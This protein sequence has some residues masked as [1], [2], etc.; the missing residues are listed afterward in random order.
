MS[1]SGK[2][3][4]GLLG[5][6]FGGPLGAIAGVYIGH[7][8][9]ASKPNSGVLNERAVFQI[10]LISILAYVAKV[11]GNVDRREVD[12]IFAFF[13]QIGFG[14]LQMQAIERTLNF[15]LTQDIHLESTCRNFRKASN[16]ESCLMLLRVVYLVVMADQK[17]HKNEKIAIEQIANYLGISDYDFEMLRAEFLKSDDK[18]YK[19]LGLEPGASIAEVKKA[20]RKLAL[21]YHPDRV[22]H[23]GK[24]Y[25]DV[26]EEKFKKINEAHEKVTK[27]LQNV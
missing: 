6:M 24:E 25:S 8:I 26:A 13:R 17:V 14:S 27:E 3:W 19:I 1:V 23:L 22:A 10:N 18:Y 16:Y 4:G 12:T 21:Q 7:Q 5:M 11:D 2:F 9:D 20:Y 15:A